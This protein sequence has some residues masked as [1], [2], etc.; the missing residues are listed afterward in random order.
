MQVRGPQGWT[1]PL[2]GVKLSPRC[3][4]PLF[5]LSFF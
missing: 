3:E 4:D 1:L 5:A 2:L